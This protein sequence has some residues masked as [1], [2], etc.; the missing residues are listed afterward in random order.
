[1][2]LSIDFWTRLNACL[3]YHNQRC[4]MTMLV[5]EMRSVPRCSLRHPCS[6]SSSVSPASSHN[7]QNKSFLVPLTFFVTDAH[8]CTSWLKLTMTIFYR[9]IVNITILYISVVSTTV[10]TITTAHNTAI[11]IP[12][13][14]T[15]CTSLPL[16]HGDSPRTCPSNVSAH[17][18]RQI[19]SAHF[20][21]SLLYDGHHTS[22]SLVSICSDRPTDSI[23]V[24]L[25]VDTLGSRQCNTEHS[26][27]A[28]CGHSL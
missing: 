27:T 19:E 18:D 7:C 10:L 14:R 28:S 1:M 11:S 16:V 13:P 9:Q 21:V 17:N 23:H 22:P 26:S 8:I 2:R 20:V 6:R 24:V 15:D 3:L 25:Y 4:D 5:W 12:V